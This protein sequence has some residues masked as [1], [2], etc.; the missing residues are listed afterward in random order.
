MCLEGD[1]ILIASHNDRQPLILVVEEDED[2]LLLISHVLIY[3]QHSFIVATNAKAAV[4]IAEEKQPNLILLELLLSQTNGLELIHVLKHG[5]L[6]KN[7]P[8]V[9]VTALARKEARSAVLAAGCD[10]YLIKPYYLNDLDR[11]IRYFL[12]A[13]HL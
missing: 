2:N 5:K 4:D 12:N 10:D 1:D 7:I 9:A 3:F 11:T 8:I 6:T 13:Q